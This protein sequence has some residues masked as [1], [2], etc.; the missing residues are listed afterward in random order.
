LYRLTHPLLHFFSWTPGFLH[1]QAMDTQ[2]AASDAVRGC[3]DPEENQDRIAM[4]LSS[5]P[6][7]LATTSFIA[8]NIR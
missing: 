4:Y 6:P 3:G 1:L 2:A 7:C 8:S 5:V